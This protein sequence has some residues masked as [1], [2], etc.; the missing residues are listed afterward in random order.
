MMENWRG[1]EAPR[2]LAIPTI[3][4]LL[5]VLNNQGFEL[6]LLGNS[7]VETLSESIRIYKARKVDVVSIDVN[8]Y[9]RKRLKINLHSNN[10]DIITM[11][12]IKQ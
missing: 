5:K 3:D 12:L 10:T 4:A 11:H 2:H 8:F 6:A 1:L 7:D 9:S